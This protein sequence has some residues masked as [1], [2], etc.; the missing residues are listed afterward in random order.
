[1]MSDVAE[2]TTAS[3][4]INALKVEAPQMPAGK[5]KECIYEVLETY[6]NDLNGH[7]G[8]GLYQMLLKEV[9]RPLLEMVLRHTRGNQTK[10]AEMLGI[11][12]GTLRKK[13][14]DH[15]LD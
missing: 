13:L 7:K 8:S 11:N 6:F 3:D 10:A 1:M 12:R 5:I 14:R 15:G 9:E 4:V 2:H